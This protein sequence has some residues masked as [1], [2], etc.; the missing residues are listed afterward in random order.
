MLEVIVQAIKA[1]FYFLKTRFWIAVRAAAFDDGWL[2]GHVESIQNFS[3]KF[4]QERILDPAL[5]SASRR[6]LDP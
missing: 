1:D 4:C 2:E 6:K 3:C 5:K